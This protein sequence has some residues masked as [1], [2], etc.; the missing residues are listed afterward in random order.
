MGSVER[1]QRDV[2]RWSFVPDQVV[3]TQRMVRQPGRATR[4]RQRSV[5]GMDFVGRLEFLF[6]QLRLGQHAAR[7]DVQWWE[8]RGS[9]R[10]RGEML[11][12]LSATSPGSHPSAASLPSCSSH[13]VKTTLLSSSGS[14]SEKQVWALV[15]VQFSVRIGCS[16]SHSDALYGSPVLPT[17]PGDEG[18]RLG[19]LPEHRRRCGSHPHRSSASAVSLQRRLPAL[20]E[21]EGV[22]PVQCSVRGNGDLQSVL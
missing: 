16:Q 17:H 5:F 4:V 8:M 7:E 10:A 3:R 6:R 12:S 1:M 22:E 18:L 15:G 2:W 19:T 13:H 21:L 20:V 11:Q 14:G 9:H